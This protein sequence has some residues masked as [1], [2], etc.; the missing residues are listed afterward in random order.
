MSKKF[1]NTLSDALT[2]Y[3]VNYVGWGR[4]TRAEYWWVFLF[5]N[6]LAMSVMIGLGLDF[7]WQLACIVPSFCL[8]ARRL[9]DTGRSNWNICWGLLPIV[10]WIILLVFLCQKGSTTANKFGPARLKK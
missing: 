10:G 7:L 9:H 6:I 8:T 1:N 4:A 2:E 5:Y 3:W